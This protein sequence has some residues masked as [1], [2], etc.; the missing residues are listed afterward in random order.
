MDYNVPDLVLKQ[1]HRLEPDLEKNGDTWKDLLHVIDWTT[2]S[3]VASIHPSGSKEAD[4]GQEIVFWGETDGLDGLK[5]VEHLLNT[6]PGLTLVISGGNYS[7]DID[8]IGA[9]DMFTQLQKVLLEKGWDP[10]TIKQRVIIDSMSI[11]TGHQRRILGTLLTSLAPRHIWVVLPKYHIPRFLMTV[12]LPMHEKGFRPTIVPWAFGEWDKHHAKKGPADYP[13]Q[14]FTYE[15][16]LALP[17]T[18]SRHKGKQDCGELDKVIRYA[19]QG[20][21]LTFRQAREWLKI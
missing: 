10:K 7:Q 4:W 11:H 5:A 3:G 15:E 20:E 6:K 13:H 2:H 18:T 14:N 9:L 16:L 19:G 21:A 1:R 17:P 8:N 12:G